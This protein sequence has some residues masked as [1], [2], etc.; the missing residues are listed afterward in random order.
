MSEPAPPARQAA[1]AGALKRQG[2]PLARSRTK[3][4]KSA[5]TPTQSSKK[6]KSGS[7]KRTAASAASAQQSAP[8]GAPRGARPRG[9]TSR[10]PT[11]NARRAENAAAAEAASADESQDESRNRNNQRSNPRP[12]RAASGSP[13][14]NE[15]SLADAEERPA[16]PP[17]SASAAA[18][19]TEATL[20]RE[21]KHR[22]QWAAFDT[23]LLSTFVRAKD[24]GGAF[25][26]KDEDNADRLITWLVQNVTHMPPDPLAAL[27]AEWKSFYP[28]ARADEVPAMATD[29][30]S[31]VEEEAV[32]DQ[33]DDAADDG[34]G[35]SDDSDGDDQHGDGRRS[36][37][38]D[39]SNTY[40]EADADSSGQQLAPQG[41]ADTADPTSVRSCLTCAEPAPPAAG[42]SSAWK[43]GCGARGDLE[44]AHA[45]NV[46]L[47][48]QK[49]PA[50]MGAP[51]P[52]GAPLG[53]TPTP[54]Q[55]GTP[56]TPASTLSSTATHLERAMLRLVIEAQDRVFEDFKP[57]AE[58]LT[59][60]LIAQ[61]L[62]M[63]FNARSY[64]P[65][66]AC[67][68]S[69]LQAGL[70]SNLA[71][72]RQ[73][74]F[75]SVAAE[76]EK[77]GNSISLVGGQLV[78]TK[79]AAPLAFTSL[80][81]FLD[82][83]IGSVIPRLLIKP[84]A[85]LAWCVIAR[86]VSEL[87]RSRGWEAASAYMEQVLADRQL[88]GASIAPLDQ[89]VLTSLLQERGSKREEK[90]EKRDKPKDA[91][92]S[93]SKPAPKGGGGSGD[94]SATRSK[95]VCHKFNFATSGCFPP[96]ERKHVCFYCQK[97]HAGKECSMDSPEK[98]P[99]ATPRK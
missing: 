38:E 43:C 91:K 67:V 6:R 5:S 94:K 32:S 29:E 27:Q 16:F 71:Y 61:A 76:V 31:D 46:H 2:D 77:A 54:G 49:A 22:E 85:A 39:Y 21:S 81:D 78:P 30:E 11:K 82:T 25:P 74:T 36:E 34:S 68:E 17:L 50:P 69:A 37:E 18:I 47:R 55:T 52:P 72:L 33:D 48:G 53:Q 64:A 99:A 93:S 12:P 57:N 98:R 97:K 45:I 83:L 14:L 15:E 28:R 1:A 59:A 24:E 92:R 35:G 3:K 58:P 84:H 96:C 65:N 60:A 62:K 4:K 66:A 23:R 19:A 73:R 41:R 42:H 70:L 79:V 95:E 44:F 56:L 8:R 86:T 9:R 13:N 75:K 7:S 88:T 20:R 63:S 51:A 90:S 40:S 89:Q 10:A 80:A 87:E 26:R